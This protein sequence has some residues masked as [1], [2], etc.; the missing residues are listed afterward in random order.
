[1][2]ASKNNQKY[3]IT[4]PKPDRKPPQ[5]KL[6]ALQNYKKRDLKSELVSRTF[7]WSIPG[8]LEMFLAFLAFLGKGIQ[9]NSENYSI[10]ALKPVQK[11]PKVKLGALQKYNK[12]DLKLPKCCI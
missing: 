8:F 3:F 10:R 7:I 1:M 11:P 5:I 2:K 12:Y 9:K 4:V 6:R